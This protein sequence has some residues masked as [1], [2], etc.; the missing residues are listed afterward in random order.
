MSGLEAGSSKQH[1]AQ[2]RDEDFNGKR[3]KEHLQ[4]LERVCPKH[5]KNSE[6]EEQK[7][8]ELCKII[9]ENHV[10]P[11]KAPSAATGAN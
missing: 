5:K 4:I 7:I 10:A 1:P 11:V 9:D 2:G 3:L 6:M 8:S